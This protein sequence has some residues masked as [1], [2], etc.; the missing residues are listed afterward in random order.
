MIGIVPNKHLVRIEANRRSSMKIPQPSLA[1]KARNLP[2]SNVGFLTSFDSDSCLH[3]LDMGLIFAWKLSLHVVF[4]E[5]CLT[6]LEKGTCCICRMHV[7]AWDLSM[8]W[9]HAPPVSFGLHLP[10]AESRLHQHP[11]CITSTFCKEP[12]KQGNNNGCLNDPSFPFQAPALFLPLVVSFPPLNHR[13]RPALNELRF[14]LPFC[15]QELALRL[16]M[17]RNIKLDLSNLPKLCN[18]IQ[19][20]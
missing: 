17:R 3:L 9:P 1:L 4:Q 5:P 11:M 10:L 8:L 18:Q 20:A 16:G 7:R 19:Q 13:Q 6:L 14:H 12:K 2:K 15:L